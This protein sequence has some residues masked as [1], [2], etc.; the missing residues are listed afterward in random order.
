ML[1]KPRFHTASVGNGHG[2]IHVA[3]VIDA[4]EAQMLIDCGVAY[5]GVPLV[6]GYHKED[7]SV[8]EAAAIV[9][10]SGGSTTF[11]LI[12][13]LNEPGAILDLC[14]ALGVSMVQLH[15]DIGLEELTR[16]RQAA[17]KLRIIKSLI[18]RPDNADGLAGEVTACAPLVDGFITDTFD[19][20]TGATGATG[21]I[22]DWSVS[23]CLVK[24]SPKPVILAGGLNADNVRGAIRAVRP[25]GV[26]VHTGVEGPDGRKRRDMVERFVREAREGFAELS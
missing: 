8:T 21:K 24:L 2:L 4:A 3:G 9:A 22:H 1:P 7:L 20:A 11:F 5:L 23:A 25:A 16:L 14:G 15:G 19:P 26:D 13:Y 17:P 10:R 18:V 12:T 6:L